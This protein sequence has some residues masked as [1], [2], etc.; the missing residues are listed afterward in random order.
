MLDQN[1]VPYYYKLQN[2]RRPIMAA[3]GKKVRGAAHLK[4]RGIPH[5]VRE[6]KGLSGEPSL[7]EVG[8]AAYRRLQAKSN[9]KSNRRGGAYSGR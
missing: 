9:G 4:E 1:F 6:T 2:G 5:G 7:K 8:S 3:K